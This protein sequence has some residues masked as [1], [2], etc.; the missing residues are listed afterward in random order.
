MIILLHTVTVSRYDVMIQGS[1]LSSTD[2]EFLLEPSD[3]E[4]LYKHEWRLS[5]LKAPP[6]PSRVLESRSQ[7]KPIRHQFFTT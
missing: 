6:D 4:Q 5:M 2:G 7:Y 3:K 1:L